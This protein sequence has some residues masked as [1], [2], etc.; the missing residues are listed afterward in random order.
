M[1]SNSGGVALFRRQRFETRVI[2]I[3][4][5]RLVLLLEARINVHNTLL[6]GLLGTDGLVNFLDQ[7]LTPLLSTSQRGL[8]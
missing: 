5:L 8:L 7:R 3:G 4:F 6:N 1:G 2:G